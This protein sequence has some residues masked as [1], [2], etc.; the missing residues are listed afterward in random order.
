M[1]YIHNANTVYTS[2]MSTTFHGA[3][4]SYS[5]RFRKDEKSLSRWDVSSPSRSV[6]MR[7][8]PWMLVYGMG[9]VSLSRY[10]CTPTIWCWLGCRPDDRSTTSRGGCAPLG[11]TATGARLLLLLLLLFARCCASSSSEP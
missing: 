10:R 6:V 3:M 9:K 8:T 5:G 2:P 11:A 1:Q 4:S 7:V